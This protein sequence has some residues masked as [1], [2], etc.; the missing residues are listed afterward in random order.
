MNMKKDVRGGQRRQA[1]RSFAAA[2][3]FSLLAAFSV[4]A[5][6]PND[7]PGAQEHRP[8]VIHRAPGT[9]VAAGRNAVPSGPLA[10]RTYRLEE[11]K[12]PSP[13]EF[14]RGGTKVVAESALRLTITLDS[15]LNGAFTINVGDEQRQAV[16]TGPHTLSALF[17]DP[18]DLEDGATISVSRGSGCL[19]EDLSP[20]PERLALPARLK[21][22]RAARKEAGNLVRRVR[23]IP[24]AAAVRG[25]PDVEIELITTD[26]FPVRNQPMVLQIGDQEFKRDPFRHGSLLVFRLTAEEFARAEDGARVKVKYGSCSSGGVRFGQLDKRALDQ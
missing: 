21:A 1:T 18:G 6:Q 12:L 14:K 11:V 9:L 25:A 3:A 16:V 5:Q 10:G 22:A 26:E 23:S 4:N 17:L 8:E 20:L 15:T 19:V 2:L 7:A 13:I 24:E